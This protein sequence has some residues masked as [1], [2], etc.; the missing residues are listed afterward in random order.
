MVGSA[1]ASP[2]WIELLTVPA[3]DFAVVV[4]DGELAFVELASAILRPYHRSAWRGLQCRRCS[5]PYAT[6]TDP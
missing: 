5:P 2:R 3:I 4:G 1:Y 6:T